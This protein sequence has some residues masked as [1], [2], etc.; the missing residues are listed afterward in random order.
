MIPIQLIFLGYFTELK[1]RKNY[2]L[3][4]TVSSY[5]N[6]KRLVR[7]IDESFSKVSDPSEGL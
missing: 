3:A 7:I 5:K 4:A 1:Q 2:G 6:L